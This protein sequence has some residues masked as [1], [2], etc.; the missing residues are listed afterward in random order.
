VETFQLNAT[1]LLSNNL[2]T[3][4]ITINKKVAAATFVAEIDYNVAESS[5]RVSSAQQQGQQV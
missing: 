5:S 1:S 3:H 2:K 4:K